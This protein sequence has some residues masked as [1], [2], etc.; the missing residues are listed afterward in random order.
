MCLKFCHLV[1]SLIVVCN[2]VLS[3]PKIV[4]GLELN[5]GLI[6]SLPNKKV[7]DWSKFKTFADYTINVAQK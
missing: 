7:L 5:A 4:F 1:K 6:N 2:N 3:S